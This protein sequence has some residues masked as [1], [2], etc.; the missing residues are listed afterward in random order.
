[1]RRRLV[2]LQGEGGVDFRYEFQLFLTLTE[3]GV[4][5]TGLAT[6][7]GALKITGLPFGVEDVVDYVEFTTATSIIKNDFVDIEAGAMS[8]EGNSLGQIF[9]VFAPAVS[10]SYEGWIESVSIIE[11]G[12]NAVETTVRIRGRKFD[13]NTME[14]LGGFDDIAEVKIANWPGGPD[15]LGTRRS[16]SGSWSA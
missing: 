3:I 13:P 12:T 15:P 2:W 11:P 7:K 5:T 10:F 14:M 8:Q 9:T 4:P 6:S 1:M 16:I